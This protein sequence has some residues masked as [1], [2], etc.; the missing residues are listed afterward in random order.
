MKETTM[1][2]H[3]PGPWA[4]DAIVQEHMFGK[5]KCIWQVSE[6]GSLAHTE[7]LAT[8]WYYLHPGDSNACLIAA[9]PELLEACEAVIRCEKTGGQGPFREVVKLAHA[10]IAKAKG[11]S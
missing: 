9:A 1:T 5:H 4:A 7:P 8:V 6:D 10:A 2:E 3:T 11:K